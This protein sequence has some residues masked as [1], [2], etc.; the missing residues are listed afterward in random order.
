MGCLGRAL[1]NP[2]A[3]IVMGEHADRAAILSQRQ[4]GVADNTASVIQRYLSRVGRRRIKLAGAPA[5]EEHGS[6][7]DGETRRLLQHSCKS[8]QAHR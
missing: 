2:A 8:R 6:P 5:D 4:L 3:R 1:H 7:L